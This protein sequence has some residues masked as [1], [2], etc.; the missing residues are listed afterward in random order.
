MRRNAQGSLGVVIVGKIDIIKLKKA[1]GITQLPLA[2]K[3]FDL[4][5]I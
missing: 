1:V 2:I 3:I 5:T 4:A